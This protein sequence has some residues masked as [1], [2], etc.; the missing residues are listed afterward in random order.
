MLEIFSQ[1]GSKEIKFKKS[2]LEMK[3]KKKHIT[4]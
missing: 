1:V 3:L 2:I 4:L